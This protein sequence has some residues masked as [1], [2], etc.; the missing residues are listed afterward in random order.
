MI[1]PNWTAAGVWVAAL[2]FLGLLIRQVGPWH[3]QATDAEK[4]FR[5]ELIKRVDKLERRQE[6]ER[7]RHNAER[8]IDRHRL[9]NV[10]A[11]FDAM[12]LL[13]K[14]SPEKAPE[15]VQSIEE[16]RAR[17]R[18]EEAV[19]KARIHAA[20][21]IATADHQEDDGEIEVLDP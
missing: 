12:V 5:D 19:E 20:L 8:A 4:A 16:M 17:Q 7:A 14:T 9:N 6:R 18:E 2:S 11:C 13:V 3:K 1:E 10:T 15:I 21:I